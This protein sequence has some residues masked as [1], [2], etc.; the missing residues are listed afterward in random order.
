MGS[1]IVDRLVPFQG[2]KLCGHHQKEFIFQMKYVTFIHNDTTQLS[3][4]QNN[5]DHVLKCVDYDK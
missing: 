1:A 5:T 2:V 4:L 3:V